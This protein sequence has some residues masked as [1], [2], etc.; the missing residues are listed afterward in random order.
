MTAALTILTVAGILVTVA[1]LVAVVAAFYNVLDRIALANE[2][3]V[4]YIERAERRQAVEAMGSG[5]GGT[6]IPIKRPDGDK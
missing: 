1:A 6:L 5:D 4:A 2:R 3:Q